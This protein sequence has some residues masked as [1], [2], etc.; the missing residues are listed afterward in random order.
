MVTLTRAEKLRRVIVSMLLLGVLG[1]T[2]YLV[3][4]DFSVVPTATVQYRDGSLTL[5]LTR[6]GQLWSTSF[7]HPPTAH[8]YNFNGSANPRRRF[9]EWQSGRLGVGVDNPDSHQFYGY[10]AET[11]SVFPS[12]AF[13]QTLMTPYPAAVHPHQAAETILAVQTANTYRTGLLNYVIVSYT[14]AGSRHLL[15]IGYANGRIQA[16]K[17]YIL[18]TVSHAGLMK[19]M[20]SL[21]VTVSTNGHNIFRVW[22]GHQLLYAGHNLDMHIEPPFQVYL[23]VQARGTRYVADFRS[24]AVYRSD[25]FTIAGL[26]PGSRITLSAPSGGTLRATAGPNGAAVVRLPV[27]A[28]GFRTAVSISEPGLPAAVFRH[29]SVEGGDVYTLT[30]ASFFRK[31]LG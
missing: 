30:S 12:G 31:L 9:L 5:R 29:V 4:G 27:N 10:F 18:Q 24:L 2:G 26:K 16:A 17:T 6:P 15:Q 13:V 25:M 11:Q 8:H 7:Q 1:W 22:L 28:L 19:A 20:Q 14:Q 23:E 21:A 3:R